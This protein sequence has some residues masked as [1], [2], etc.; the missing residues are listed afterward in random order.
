[1][2]CH[3]AMML[4]MSLNVFNNG[5][6]DQSLNNKEKFF[7][8]DRKRTR[9][10]SRLPKSR[11]GGRG[12]YFRSLHYLGRRSEAQDCKNLKKVKCG[13]RMDRRTDRQTDG[14]TNG[15]TD[16]AGCRVA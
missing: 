16:K 4:A 6:M 13:G 5:P 3:D 12:P 15:P 2:N 1:M 10:D 8:L 7:Y 9:P 14:R 11:A